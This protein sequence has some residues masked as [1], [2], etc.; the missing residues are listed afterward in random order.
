MKNKANKRKKFAKSYN[1]IKYTYTLYA[2]QH[3]NILP[4]YILI[5][6]IL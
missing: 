3:L 6:L 5:N 4:T 1:I 2:I